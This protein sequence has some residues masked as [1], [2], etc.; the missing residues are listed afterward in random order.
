MY[1]NPLKKVLRAWD[2]PVM[3]FAVSYLL[4]S[5][6]YDVFSKDNWDKVTVFWKFSYEGNFKQTL[7]Q[8]V[9]LS[10]TINCFKEKCIYF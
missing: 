10:K 4:V 9:M 2:V 3:V 7:G 1:T 8:K 5:M 6:N